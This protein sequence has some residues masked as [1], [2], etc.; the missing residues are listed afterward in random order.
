MNERRLTSVELVLFA[1][2]RAALEMGVGLLISRR[3]NNDQRV[4]AGVALTVVGGITT[5]PIFLKLA[6]QA[7]A[8]HGM[9]PTIAA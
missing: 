3:F 9:R 2:T 4:A 1:I 7:R 6:G 5:V 8:E